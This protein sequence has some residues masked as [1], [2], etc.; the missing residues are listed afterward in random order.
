[1]QFA[2]RINNLFSYISSMPNIIEQYY[3]AP[4][5]GTA[6]D[7]TSGGTS[8]Q[9]LTRAHS[10]QQAVA[11]AAA[12]AA[13]GR[14][15]HA[16][17]LSAGTVGAQVDTGHTTAQSSSSS[18]STTTAP[19]IAGAA[20][21]TVISSSSA[22]SAALHAAQRAK[23]GQSVVSASADRSAQGLSLPSPTPAVTMSDA[24]DDFVKVD[25]NTSKSVVARGIPSS[26]SDTLAA[27]IRPAV[28]AAGSGHGG[29]VADRAQ[30]FHFRATSDSVASASGAPAPRLGGGVS[31]L[32]TAAT[33][34]AADRPVTTHL[35]RT[36][37]AMA[38]S[39]VAPGAVSPPSNTTSIAGIAPPA[40]SSGPHSSSGLAVML[41]STHDRT[42][43]TR[44]AAPD[45]GIQT[46]TLSSDTVLSPRAGGDAT[47][48]NFASSLKAVVKPAVSRTISTH[49]DAGKVCSAG[50]SLPSQPPSLSALLHSGGGKSGGSA[51]ADL[52]KSAAGKR[53]S[54]FQLLREQFQKSTAP[55]SGTSGANDEDKSK[56]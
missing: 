42:I 23:S 52:A 46:R 16:S 18:S 53:S 55:A 26:S 48:G 34:A 19:H 54:N 15:H 22:L 47:T 43:P 37:A 20:R 1:M 7:P 31:A 35:N 41:R 45:P 33:A 13:V 24:E 38:P 29:S 30:A 4:T 27:S 44:A 17:H 39:N 8:S 49:S 12:A 56:K 36:S 32:A 6:T 50:A 28:V 10:D 14:L 40:V 3:R 51:A 5:G 11:T 9:G 25:P 21:P 2:D